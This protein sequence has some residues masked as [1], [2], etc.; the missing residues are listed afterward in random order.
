VP[1]W[2]SQEGVG[3]CLCLTRLLIVYLEW[4]WSQKGAFTT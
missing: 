4:S 2:T 1:M 3:W